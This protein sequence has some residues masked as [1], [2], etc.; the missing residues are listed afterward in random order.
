MSAPTGRPGTLDQQ[1]CF[2]IYSANAAIHRM[3]RPHLSKLGLTYPQ[4]ITLLALWER[5]DVTVGELGKR[6]FLETNTLTPLLKRLEAVGHLTRTRDPRDERVVRVRLTHGGRALQGEASDALSCIHTLAE[7]AGT[8]LD[9]WIEA[10]AALREQA[11]E[12]AKAT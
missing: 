2:A 3:Y 8:D 1:L 6:L 10:L 5:D 4:Y 7:E 9:V 12:A 11:L